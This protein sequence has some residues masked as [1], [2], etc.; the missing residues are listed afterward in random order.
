MIFD[1]HYE[2]KRVQYLQ[3][4]FRHADLFAE[5]GFHFRDRGSHPVDPSAE[6]YI[7]QNPY[8]TAAS[9]TWDKP[10]ILAERRDSAVLFWR[11]YTMHPN[12]RAIWKLN[13]AGFAIQNVRE[14]YHSG[15]LGAP[16][17]SPLT[18]SISPEE[19]A[20]IHAVPHYGLFEPMR[21]WLDNPTP[22]MR[23]R[24]SVSF[25]G[26][27]HYPY[28]PEIGLHRKSAIAAISKIRRGHASIG[29]RHVSEYDREISQSHAVASPWG[30]GE[31]CWR[32]AEAMF[33]GVPLIKPWTGYVRTW[34]RLFGN[35]DYIACS[36]DFSD[37]D[38]CV[39]IATGR[40]HREMIQRNRERMRDA[41]RAEAI[42]EQMLPGL[43][44]C[45]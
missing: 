9:L 5:C 43:L 13:V 37:L 6:A 18:R 8:L 27:I 1:V 25:R 33:A 3:L 42:V 34:P 14:R 2:D 32:D 23:K 39:E 10:I 45:L 21:R 36:P 12:I 24:Y 28:A 29:R 17:A 41:W 26:K 7:L 19:Y 30:Y 44:A 4:L 31:T 15:L 35:G 16:D 38:K 40:D 22:A 11:H 20:K